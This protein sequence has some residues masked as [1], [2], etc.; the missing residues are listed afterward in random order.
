M[1]PKAGLLILILSFGLSPRIVAQTT[2]WNGPPDGHW[3][4]PLNWTNGVPTATSYASIS[5]PY[6]D[7]L[8]PID[9]GE[10][11][12]QVQSLELATPYIRLTNG[13]LD[14]QIV[15]G[16]N[17]Y[18][19]SNPPSTLGV[20]VTSHAA[21]LQLYGGSLGALYVDA[22]VFGAGLA[23]QSAYTRFTAANTYSGPTLVTQAGPVYFSGQG[24]ALQSSDF[25]LTGRLVLDNSTTNLPD[26]LND[27]ASVHISGGGEL[28]IGGNATA[29][30]SERVGL[31][32]I[33]VGGGAIT[34]AGNNQPITLRAAGMHVSGGAF[35][36]INFKPAAGDRIL[37]DAPPALVG[38]G[39]GA[40][41]TAR[42]IVPGVFGTGDNPFTYD[43]GDPTKPQ[44][45]PG[46][47]P[48]DLATEF[49]SAVPD[50]S[51]FPANV[52]L[53]TS[54]T[55]TSDTAVN[56]LGVAGSTTATTLTLDHANLTVNANSMSLG[57]AVITGEGGSLRFPGDAIIF[58]DGRLDVPIHAHSIVLA[59]GNSFT[60]YLTRPNDIPGGIDLS[61]RLY[62]AHP[63]ALGSGPVHVEG[64]SR[65]YFQTGDA[66]IPNDFIVGDTTPGPDSYQQQVLIAG[67]HGSTITFKGNF[68]GS[69]T[70]IAFRGANFRLDAT[71]AFDLVSISTE[72]WVELN[73]TLGPSGKVPSYVDLYGKLA[74]SGK[75]VGAAHGGTIDPG[76]LGKPGRLNVY[77]AYD[78]TLNIDITGPDP[79]TEYDQ[80]ILTV[81][82]NAVHLHVNLDPAFTPAMG[83]SF[84]IVDDQ[85][86][87]PAF[88]TF[89]ELPDGAILQANDTLF[90]ISYTAGD[91]NDIALTVV[92]EPAALAL[93]AFCIPLFRRRRN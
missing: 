5:Y 15:I 32:D 37:L 44:N 87:G 83:E 34:L 72:G 92:P 84:L 62:V 77:Q 17:G 23:V 13:S 16:Q 66:T 19:K 54:Q 8:I 53:T 36:Y 60:W 56:F 61:G 64:T 70:G 75:L 29:P 40:P 6:I 93:A 57:S 49:A 73:G 2:L 30:M 65:L 68:S 80:L 25:Q 22:P 1:P 71:M 21:M 14:A 86:P 90:Q 91:G 20:P 27:V 35:A 89:S 42:G 81:L 55:R 26:R 45:A 39:A 50:P 58:G 59:G 52:L 12:R 43:T 51:P 78:C 48:L 3:G 10:V 7:A 33:G 28:L 24:S 69:Q 31:I 41:P 18:D 11:Q 79:A 38:G 67:M 82:G 4:D 9:L 47:R 85:L 46:L 88:A 63:L 76:P 74:G